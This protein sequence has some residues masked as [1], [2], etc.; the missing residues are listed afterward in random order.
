MATDPDQ[1]GS[2]HDLAVE[3]EADVEALATGLAH[4]GVDPGAVQQ[5]TQCA[6][7][8]RGIIKALGAAPDQGSPQPSGGQDQ[9]GSAVAQFHQQQVA[10]AQ[11]PG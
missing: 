7:I 3:A 6:T 11:Q 10:G 4:A 2:L 5:V 1:P 8:L 9:L